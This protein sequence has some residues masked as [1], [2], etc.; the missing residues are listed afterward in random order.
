MESYAKG[1]YR[2]VELKQINTFEQIQQFVIPDRAEHIELP[3]IA[4]EEQYKEKVFSDESDADADIGQ[5]YVHHVTQHFH[6]GD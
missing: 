6:F 4:V 3:T 1:G 2:I 5:I